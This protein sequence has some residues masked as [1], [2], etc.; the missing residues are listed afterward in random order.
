[1][2]SIKNVRKVSVFYRLIS[3]I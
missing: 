1:M 3:M 2:Q